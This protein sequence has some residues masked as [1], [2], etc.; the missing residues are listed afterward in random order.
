M[1]CLDVVR[2]CGALGEGLQQQRLESYR[3][4]ARHG[5][6]LC[7]LTIVREPASEGF[8]QSETSCSTS[9]LILH[10]APGRALE[11]VG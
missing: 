10:S 9:N 11:L 5:V 8:E 7:L 4:A 3:V 1:H 2:A 6:Y